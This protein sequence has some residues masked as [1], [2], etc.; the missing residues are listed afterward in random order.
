MNVN[1]SVAKTNV[2]ISVAPQFSHPHQMSHSYVVK[3]VGAFTH[4]KY[5]ALGQPQPHIVWFKDGTQLTNG[6]ARQKWVLKLSDLQ[7]QDSGRYTCRVHNQA[8]SI[9]F[10]YTVKVVGKLQME[11]DLN[12]ELL[13]LT[14]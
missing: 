1:I 9:S 10:T 14:Y 2:S 11:G 5:L 12:V 7:F 6:L 4:L 13:Y 3:P 8:G